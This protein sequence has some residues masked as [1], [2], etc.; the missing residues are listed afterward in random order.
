MKRRFRFNPRRILAPLTE[1]WGL[2]LIALL[3]AL[4][5]YHALKPADTSAGGNTDHPD[6]ERKLF[7]QH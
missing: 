1:N 4:V 3:L 5:I 7:Q 6:N 2:K